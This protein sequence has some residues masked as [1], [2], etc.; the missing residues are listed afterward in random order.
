MWIMTLNT[1]LLYY[2][3]KKEINLEIFWRHR[4]MKMPYTS[5]EDILDNKSK[6]IKKISMAFLYSLFC[7]FFKFGS[8]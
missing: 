4:N 8:E 5:L 6:A 1:C 7:I 2:I 3:S